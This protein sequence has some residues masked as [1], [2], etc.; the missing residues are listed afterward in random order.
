MKTEPFQWNSEYLLVKKTMKLFFLQSYL[1]EQFFTSKK[2]HVMLIR[3]QNILWMSRI[4][5]NP[6]VVT[7]CK[8]ILQF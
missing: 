4:V 2:Y 7:Y 1:D 6:P 8:E 5:F 3:H